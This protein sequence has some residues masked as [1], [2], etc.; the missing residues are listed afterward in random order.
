MNVQH[1]FQA[2]RAAT[3][4]RL[5]VCG[6][7]DSHSACHGTRASISIKN[8]AF[9]VMRPCAEKSVDFNLTLVKLL[10]FIFFVS[11]N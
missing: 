3:V 11:M 7:I 6:S 1:P 5:R 9:L 10:C 4:A 2:D 8:L